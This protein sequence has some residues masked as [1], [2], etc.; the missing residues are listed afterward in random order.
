MSKQSASL[1]FICVISAIFFTLLVFSPLATLAVQSNSPP[2]LPLAQPTAAVVLTEPP[3]TALP[4]A[5]FLNEVN[6]EPLPVKPIYDTL[7][8]AVRKARGLSTAL[9]NVKP[10]YGEKTVYLTFDDGPNPENTP[11]ILDILQK[12]DIKATFF[13]LGTEAQKYPEILRRTYEAGHAVGNH[14][15]NHIY[16][17]LYHSADSYFAQLYHND[18][19][20]M[21]SLGVRPRISRAPGGAAG[22]FTREYWDRL[23]ADGYVDVGWNISSGDASRAKA[24]QLISNI[25]H[26]LDNKSLWSH[27][28]VLMHDGA[29]H[30]ATVQ[31]LPEIINIFKQHGFEFRVVNL[32]TPPAW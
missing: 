31:A 16:R 1:R 18:E 19:I 5:Y 8:T 7:T 11:A 13:V 23:Q 30:A 26:Q 24:P 12:H 4:D 2:K 29:G 28:I 3:G 22:S 15:Y 32:E 6:Y 21:N 10:Y 20:I 14:S 9:P 25:R 17:E 27:A